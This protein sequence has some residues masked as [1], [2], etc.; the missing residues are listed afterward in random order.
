MKDH[1]H[2]S[3]SVI[4]REGRR[5]CESGSSTPAVVMSLVVHGTGTELGQEVISATQL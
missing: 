4:N 2:S 1:E 3:I 5:H